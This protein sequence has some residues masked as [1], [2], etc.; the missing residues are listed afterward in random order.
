M[1]GEMNL[2]NAMDCP[3]C[4]KKYYPANVVEYQDLCIKCT[5]E[6]KKES[7][8][9]VYWLKKVQETSE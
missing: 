3:R 2:I 4:G 6:I 8:K 7:A 9:D 1:G 5:E